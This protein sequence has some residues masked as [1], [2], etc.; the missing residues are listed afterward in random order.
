MYNVM[1][2]VVRRKGYWGTAGGHE[3][4]RYMVRLAM[5]RVRDLT[6]GFIDHV[7]GHDHGHQ[8]LMYM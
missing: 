1:T 6:R 7:H 3:H 5:P 4:G 2:N 8:I